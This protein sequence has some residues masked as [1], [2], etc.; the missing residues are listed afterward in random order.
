MATKGWMTLWLSFLVV[1]GGSCAPYAHYETASA[2]P[3][4]VVYTRYN[5]HYISEMGLHRASYANWT[6]HAGHR[7]L[8]Y[9][10]R[11]RARISENA[12][13]FM[14]ADTG[15]QIDLE[16]NAGHMR[17][18]AWD[19]FDL[20]TSRTPVTYEGLSQVDRQGIAAGKARVGMS[21]QGVLVALG[22]PATH[23]TPSLDRNRWF[24]WKARRGSYAVEFDHDGNVVRILD[25]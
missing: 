15:M 3:T 20:I 8:P 16:Y 25:E 9:N 7:V 1:M 23:R 13:S 11:V 18:S 14:V 2:W 12:I 6:Q 19:Y 4:E 17:M 10:T 5:L 22:Y 24:Y 21:K